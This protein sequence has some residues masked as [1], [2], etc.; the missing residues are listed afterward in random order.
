[1]ELTINRFHGQTITAIDV[2]KVGS[3]KVIFTLESGDRIRMYHAKDC[4]ETVQVRDLSPA[5]MSL[6]GQKINVVRELVEPGDKGEYDDSSTCSTYW[7]NGEFIKWVGESNGYYNETVA[8]D[9]MN[10]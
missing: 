6:V 5:F 7:L 4:C 1:M 8:I 3:E 10:K 9:L 2:A